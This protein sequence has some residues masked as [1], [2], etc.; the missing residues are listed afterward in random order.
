MPNPSPDKSWNVGF[1]DGADD[2]R[3]HRPPPRPLAATE[4]AEGL[5]KQLSRIRQGDAPLIAIGADGKNLAEIVECRLAGGGAM[6]L[7]DEHNYAFPFW[8]KWH[9]EDPVRFPLGCALLHIDAHP[10]DHIKIYP[11]NPIVL[12][13]RAPFE[14]VLAFT[15]VEKRYDIESFIF[16][17]VECGLVDANLWFELHGNGKLYHVHHN[18]QGGR[19]EVCREEVGRDKYEALIRGRVLIG[20]A[21]TDIFDPANTR[22]GPVVLTPEQ[23]AGYL[24]TATGI[25][26]ATSPGCVPT[27]KPAGSMRIARKLALGVVNDRA[28]KA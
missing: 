3:E 17:A 28:R 6:A 26:I 25:T 22:T 20:D 1:P 10:D 15:I 21:D 12:N 4:I 27:I 13:S 18:A 16:P 5:R 14:D 8:W 11:D 19:K 23:V 2:C 24:K 7:M 9:C